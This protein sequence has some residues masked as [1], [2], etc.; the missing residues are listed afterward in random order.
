MHGARRKICMGKEEKVVLVRFGRCD[1]LFILCVRVPKICC[2]L[3]KLSKASFDFL[4]FIIISTFSL[5]FHRFCKK[6]MKKC[7]KTLKVGPLG[8]ASDRIR[9]YLKLSVFVMCIRIT[10]IS[11]TVSEGLWQETRKSWK[12]YFLPSLTWFLTVLQFL[13]KFSENAESRG[14]Y[15]QSKAKVMQKLSKVI[16]SNQKQS[17]SN[18]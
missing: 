14:N 11:G 7:K 13:K 9:L 12:K 10:F 8:R 16:K 6:M 3:F 4:C 5:S 2:Y 1:K 15:L 17:K 18:Q